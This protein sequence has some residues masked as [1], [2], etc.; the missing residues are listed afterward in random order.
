MML[1]FENKPLLERIKIFDYKNPADVRIKSTIRGNLP[2]NYWKNANNPHSSLWNFTSCSSSGNIVE[3]NSPF[4][5]PPDFTNAHLK[6]F[7]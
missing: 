5:D 4:V 2:M 1:Y 3:Y 7:Y 6:H